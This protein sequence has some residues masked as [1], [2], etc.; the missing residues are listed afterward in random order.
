MQPLNSSTTPLRQEE[1]QIPSIS[2][3]RIRAGRGLYP[4]LWRTTAN[5]NRES[6]N[7][8]PRSQAHY[9]AASYDCTYSAGMAAHHPWL[10]L[11]KIEANFWSHL[12]TGQTVA[13]DRQEIFTRVASA[14]PPTHGECSKPMSTPWEYHGQIWCTP[15]TRFATLQE[16]R[17]GS[18]Q[19]GFSV[20]TRVTSSYETSPFH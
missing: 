17:S 15:Y 7:R 9:K 2:T 14:V 1:D 10:R 6:C 8:W 20:A 11:F 16:P 5:L 18:M 19:F 3:E 12:S 13:Q 4:I